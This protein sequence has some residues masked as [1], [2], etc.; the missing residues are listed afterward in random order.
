VISPKSVL[1][2]EGE[3]MPILAAE[4]DDLLEPAKRGDLYVRFNIEFPRKL[5]E[6][7]RQRL[8]AILSA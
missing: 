7:Q 8:E 2:V 3:G 1:K 6:D 5:N 4:G